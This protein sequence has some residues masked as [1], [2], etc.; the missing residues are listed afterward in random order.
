MLP[1]LV[2]FVSK[3]VSTSDDP[4]G[5]SGLDASGIG[6]QTTRTSFPFVAERNFHAGF[7]NT[8]HQLL[9]EN[10]RIEI[11]KI[12]KYFFCAQRLFC[13]YFDTCRYV[14]EQ[15]RLLFSCDTCA[16]PLEESLGSTANVSKLMLSMQTHRKGSSAVIRL[17]A[18][19]FQPMLSCSR[20]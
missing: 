3:R 5:G 1:S 4:E 19:V 11:M 17:H 7:C 12:W 6:K 16:T 8:H 9:A 2:L 20:K 13:S 15:V 18:L 14:T 10:Q